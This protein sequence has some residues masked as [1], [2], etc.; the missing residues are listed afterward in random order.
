MGS[1]PVRQADDGAKVL[2]MSGNEL[3]HSKELIS[4]QAGARY[5]RLLIF[6]SVFV[7]TELDLVVGTRRAES[8]DLVVL[9]GTIWV[10]VSS[11]AR[12]A[13]EHD[14]RLSI[15]S[16]V[17]DVILVTAFLFL[18]GGTS[19]NLYPLYYIPILTACVR[20]SVRDAIAS[21]VLWVVS[22]TM[23]G[24]SGGIDAELTTRA[25]L[26]IATFG[27]SALFMAVFFAVLIRETRAKQEQINRTSELLRRMTV[28][29]EMAQTL[30]TTLQR[31]ELLSAAADC[32]VRATEA[33]AA[34]IYLAEAPAGG[35]WMAVSGDARMRRIISESGAAALWAQETF[36]S[37]Q[38]P[39]EPGTEDPKKV[40]QRREGVRSELSV[41]FHRGAS[42]AGVLQVFNK[43]GAQAFSDEDR[44]VLVSISTQAA[45]GL[46]NARLVRELRDRLEELNA[47][48]AR[49][50]QSEKLSALGRLISGIAHEINNPLA[51]V[52]GYAEL[53]AAD[54]L[55]ERAATRLDQV[56]ESASR[57]KKIVDSLLSFARKEE[58][59]MEQTNVNGIV[60]EALQI[61]SAEFSA[62]EISVSSELDQN[63]PPTAADRHQIRQV[64]V[65]LLR[66]AVDALSGVEAPREVRVSTSRSDHSIRVEV[67]DTGEGIAEDVK[68]RVFDPFFTT[69]PTG[70]GTGLGLSVSYGIITAHR[71]TI[72]F[73]PNEPRGTV[74]RVELP[75]QMALPNALVE[76]TER[77]LEHLKVR[78]KVLVIEQDAQVRGMIAEAL[79]GLECEIVEGD[80]SEEALRLLVRDT[81]EAIIADVEMSEMSAEEFL[82]RLES[83][84]PDLAERTVFIS[85]GEPSAQAKAFL[86][87]ISNQHFCTPLDVREFQTAVWRATR[88]VRPVQ[89]TRPVENESS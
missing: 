24:Y 62:A 18:T 64:V 43:K 30:G 10:I 11:H 78:G 34:A 32:A 72:T 63:L 25:G 67:A 44:E 15:L 4:A 14:S 71:G 61:V 22:Y 41:A 80:R 28:L 12:L 82:Q 38:A 21:A 52:M 56:Y 23:L 73:H 6:V 7:M 54:E 33:E 55:P 35:G 89:Q 87:S 57:C 42:V 37:S 26:R 53:M 39:T 40:S 83:W 70:E 5:A 59:E 48:Q 68:D 74:F 60:E 31:D 46:E 58:P 19:S 77:A 49:L 75:L 79:A 20:L 29:F 16:L 51:A 76:G 27:I 2:I 65:N 86:E 1:L 13:H 36:E 81:F 50:A 66:N 85:S 84:S 47:T 9:I 45:A 17:C 88:Q 8:L 69:R 3:R